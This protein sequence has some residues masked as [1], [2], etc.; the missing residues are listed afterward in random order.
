MLVAAEAQTTVLRHWRVATSLPAAGADTAIGVAGALAGMHAGRLLVA[1]GANFPGAMPWMGGAKAYHSI[2]Y[3]FENNT[4]GTPSHTGTFR[5]P[6]PVAYGASCST[7]QGVVYAGGETLGG[8]TR[9]V[10][11]LQWP[12]GATQPVVRY[13]PELPEAVA[14]SAIATDGNRVF[15]A[16]GETKDGVSNQFLC[17]DLADT[18]KGW[19]Q[20][21]S[22]PHPVSHAVLLFDAGRRTCFLAGGRKRNAG[23][24]S[25]LYAH[26]YAFTLD[27]GNWKARQPLPYALSAGTA[28]G[29]GGGLLLLGGDRGETF[30]KAEVLIA[31]IAREQD[32]DRKAALDRQKAALQSAHPGFSKEVLFYDPET[33]TWSVAGSIPYAVPV[34]TTAL[35]WKSTAYLVSGE[36]KAGIRTPDILAATIGSFKPPGHKK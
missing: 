36:I 5:L 34:T 17:L 24:T 11:L 9:T 6:Y 7:P 26:L 18:A 8:L 28:I 12:E 15:L 22:L 16:G 14:N 2:G 21:P 29:A 33:D 32:P 31:A 1:G 35:V 30:H 13:L 10:L 19:Q 20:W 25:T 3:V 27:A 23:D 4:S